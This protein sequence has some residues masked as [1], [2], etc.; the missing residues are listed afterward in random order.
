[1]GKLRQEVPEDDETE[2]DDDDDE[3]E[4]DP[5]IFVTREQLDTILRSR[6]GTGVTQQMWL[7]MIPPG[8]YFSEFSEWRMNFTHDQLCHMLAAQGAAWLSEG[9][10][11]MVEQYPDYSMNDARIF[12]L[13]RV[14][15]ILAAGG[16][17]PLS[18]ADA[19][20]LFKSEQEI[21]TRGELNYILGKNGCASMSEENFLLEQGHE[22]DE[23]ENEE[24]EEDAQ[25]LQPSEPQQ[26]LQLQM[27]WQMV[28]HGRWERVVLN[29][30]E[31]EPVDPQEQEAAAKIQA[32]FRGIIA[33]RLAQ[34]A[35]E[36]RQ[37]RRE[38]VLREAVVKIQAL[39]RGQRT[40]D[41]INPAR[42]LLGLAC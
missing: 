40:R 25:P 29:P 28:A 34:M 37:Q 5:M 31:D 30:E 32:L 7:N 10:P 35:Q 22:E 26:P 33:R 24:E 23:D 17:G 38:A 18:D 36:Q 13:E 6:G 3:D 21:I 4:E 15:E 39:F 1:M 9:W 20:C 8:N 11:Q 14:N 16:C 42:A 12:T 27:R 19:Q 41:I 2:Y